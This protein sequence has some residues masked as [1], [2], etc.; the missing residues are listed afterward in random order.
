MQR[1][2]EKR[3]QRRGVRVHRGKKETDRREDNA[4]ILG[5]RKKNAERR[6]WRE[7]CGGKSKTWKRKKVQKLSD[8]SNTQVH[9]QRN[10][11]VSSFASLGG[12]FSNIPIEDNGEAETED[13]DN[14]GDGK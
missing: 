1:M 14:Y 7:S 8:K 13:S 3:D 10:A 6:K 11:L 12:G 5:N 9:L 4:E 2:G